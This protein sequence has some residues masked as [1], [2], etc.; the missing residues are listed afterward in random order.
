MDTFLSFGGTLASVPTPLRMS[1]DASGMRCQ[2]QMRQHRGAILRKRS[3]L[4]QRSTDKLSRVPSVRLGRAYCVVHMLCRDSEKEVGVGAHADR[5]PRQL[6][7]CWSISATLIM[8]DKQ[9]FFSRQPQ[10]CKFL[11]SHVE[12]Q[13]FCWFHCRTSAR[14]TL[15]K[16]SCFESMY[17]CVCVCVCVCVFWGAL[18]FPFPRFASS[19]HQ[20]VIG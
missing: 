14:M 4:I 11:V 20:G 13:I 5:T 6:V 10:E 2:V 1:S 7:K 15:D 3:C 8:G 17:V 9:R 18:F 16:A 19:V 12:S